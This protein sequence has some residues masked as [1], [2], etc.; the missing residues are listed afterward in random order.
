MSDQQIIPADMSS[1][2]SYGVDGFK[3]QPVFHLVVNL[4]YA[5]INSFTAGL[6]MG[7]LMVGYMRAL[8]KDDAGQPITVNDGFSGF[9]AFVPALVVG[10]VTGLAISVASIFLVIPAFIVMPLAPASLWLVANGETDPMKAMQ[11][12][13]VGVQR[14]LVPGAVA[15]LV[16]MLVIMAGALACGLGLIVTLPIGMIAFCRLGQQVASGC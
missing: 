12:A 8:K 7:P 4:L 10:V 16:I 15:S 1:C 2:I 6:L 9:D 13:W 5:I 11:R 3:K 14:N